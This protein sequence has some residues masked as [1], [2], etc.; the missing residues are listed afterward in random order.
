MKRI[1]LCIIVLLCL[2][3]GTVR[4]QVVD[5]QLIT[6][7]VTDPSGAV[8]QGATVT[9]TNDATGLSRTVK[10]NDSGVYTA[11]NL[12]IGTYSVTTVMTGFKKSVINGVIVDVGSKPSVPVALQL[13]ETGQTVTVQANAMEI[14]TTSA[15]I[16]ATISSQQATQIQLNGRNYVQL[17]TL[18]PGVS[19][20]VASGFAIFGK[21]GANG[22]SQSVNGI[23]VDSANFFVDGV[24]NK[25]N[26]GGGNNFVNISPDALDEFRD[27]ASTYDASYGGSSGATVSVAIRSGAKA[28]HGNVYEYIRND[29]IQGYSFIPIGATVTKPPLRYN[30]YGYTLGGPIYIPNRFN[31]D[32]SKLFFFWAQ[33]F[34]NVRTATIGTYSVPTPAALAAAQ[35]GPSTATGLAL[36]NTLLTSPTGVFSY[37][38]EAPSDQK[39]YVIKVDYNRSPKNQFNGHFVHDLYN[40][41][42]DQTDY[43]LY[44]RRL[45]GLTASVQWTH[46][47]DDRT[48]NVLTGSYSGNII[49][50][51][52]PS[53]IVENPQINKPILKSNYGLTY[54]SLYG[55]SPDIPQIAVTGYSL[56]TVTPFVFDNYQRIYAAKDDFSHVAGNHTLRAGAYVWR[57]RKNQ[58]APPALNGQFNFSSLASL[59]LGNFSA[60]TEGS[61]TPQVQA[62]FTQAEFYAQDDWKVSRN[63]TLNLGLRWQYMQ[64]DTSW[65]N[66]A[67]GFWPQYYNPLQAATVNPASGYI[68]NDPS[69]YNGLVLPGSGFPSKAAAVIPASIRNN[70]QVT[71]LFHNLPEGL[72]NTDYGTFAP[73]FGFAW[74]MSGKQ[75]AVLRGGFGISYERVEGNYYY[76]A[77]TQEPFVAVASLSSAG[78]VD[79]LGSVGLAASPQNI[80]NTSDPNL[81]PPRIYNYSLGIQQRLTKPML[82]EVS[83]VGTRTGNDVWMKDLNQAA[84]GTE[85]ANPT[86]ARNALRPYLGY[87]EICQF[88]NGSTL[89]YNSLQSRLQI[90]LSHGGIANVSYT[91]SKTLT[92]AESYAYT[93]QN[94]LN[95]H[96]DYGPSN[97]SQPQ[98][99]AVSY[100]YRLPFWM[101][102]HE[103]YKQPLNHWQISGVTRISSGLPINVVQASGLSTAGDLVVTNLTLANSTFTQ[104][105]NLVGNV[106]SVYAHGGKQYANPAAFVQPTAGTFGSFENDGIKGPLY[107]NWDA[108][109]Q[110]N[111]PIHDSITME[112]RAE[113]FNVPNHLSPF[114]VAGTLGKATNGAYTQNNNFG[115]VTGAADP[116]TMEFALRIGF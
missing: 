60:Y 36:S 20:T 57:G 65:P 78:N 116:R 44:H 72:V 66:N 106:G 55:A 76:S 81:D 111:I 13:G 54:A 43:I 95:L 83:Y 28:F 88:L 84:P 94:S 58:T 100:V 87:G 46:T 47:F 86:V 90:D 16:G 67:S 89:N 85:Q 59:V 51:T 15:E 77:V 92:D 110:K 8:V 11:L 74:D 32:K 3:T 38:N 37:L 29:A 69:P 101:H 103:W 30:N 39:E 62:R 97:Y 75:T 17:L 25:D 21:Y 73:R 115:Q 23:R 35:A 4:A 26:G 1:V 42:G 99:L 79:S 31:S 41:L 7:T 108:A 10:S 93:P 12:P 48:V 49:Y 70:P 105:P 104:R 24:D 22:N 56:P 112:F 61:S 27:A 19:T 45:P 18:A 64:P 53:G 82:F 109:L 5:A 33:D 71:A 91:W 114:T 2:A 52:D 98:I 40:N 34:K 14:Q 6:G 9:A 102:D 113:M 80:T 107:N 68:T 63:L 50:Q 96:A